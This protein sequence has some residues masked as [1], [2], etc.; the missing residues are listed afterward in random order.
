MCCYSHFQSKIKQVLVQKTRAS[1]SSFPYYQ[2]SHL[3]NGRI[4]IIE[5]LIFVGS[6]LKRHVVDFKVAQSRILSMFSLKYLNNKAN[7]QTNFYTV[8]TSILSTSKSSK[9]V[10]FGYIAHCLI[11]RF[12]KTYFG[13]VKSMLF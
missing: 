1:A 4:N 2:Y 13:A 9:L 3:I 5:F 8:K 12:L 10:L 11:C 7:T 6:P